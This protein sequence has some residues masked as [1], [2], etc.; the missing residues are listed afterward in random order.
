MGSSSSSKSLA[1]RLSFDDA[2]FLLAPSSPSGLLTVITDEVPSASDSSKRGQFEAEHEMFQPSIRKLY[3]DGDSYDQIEL[4]TNGTTSSGDCMDVTAGVS[5]GLP[6]LPGYSDLKYIT[7]QTLEALLAKSSKKIDLLIVDCRY[8]YEFNGGHFKSAVNLYTK[9][10][11]QAQL[12]NATISKS[13]K[14]VFHCEFSSQRAPK[15]CR[16]LRKQDR[17]A[18]VE[19]YPE[20]YYPELYVLHGG[21]KAYYEQCDTEHCQPKSYRPML[22]KQYGAERAEYRRTTKMWGRH[23]SWH[24]EDHVRTHRSVRKMNFN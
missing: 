20:L 3:K 22:H 10:L 16:F 2:D 15:L 21:Y 11:I 7:P 24:G 13:T 8:P 5:E 17:A 14:I 1:D 18:H 4:H 19:C 9:E 23:K 12:I 6:I